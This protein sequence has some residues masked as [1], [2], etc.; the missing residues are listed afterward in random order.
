MKG[1]SRQRRK[2]GQ[3]CWSKAGMWRW[4][5]EPGPRRLSGRQRREGEHCNN[6]SVPGL[7]PQFNNRKVNAACITVLPRD[8]SKIL[9]CTYPCLSCRIHP[10]SVIISLKRGTFPSGSH[11][12]LL[13]TQVSSTTGH[14]LSSRA[15]EL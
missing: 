5:M 12:D 2:L 7:S 15:M 8:Q 6:P 11:S 9:L 1:G 10:L 13:T 4:R 3:K 14:H